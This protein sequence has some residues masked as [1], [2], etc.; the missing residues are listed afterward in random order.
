MDFVIRSN[1]RSKILC[2]NCTI[3]YTVISKA[4]HLFE[5][6]SEVEIVNSQLLYQHFIQHHLDVH[7]SCSSPHK[8][9]NNKNKAILKT[10]KKALM[11]IKYSS[12]FRKNL[13]LILTNCLL[14][15]NFIKCVFLIFSPA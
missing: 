8:S 2:E 12:E 7:T 4:L 15:K 14:Q 9:N 11:F 6:K 5:T 1:L 3:T 10:S 13:M